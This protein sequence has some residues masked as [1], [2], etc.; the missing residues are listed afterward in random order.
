MDR[1]PLNHKL[2]KEACDKFIENADISVRN[3]CKIIIDNTMYVSYENFI[4]RIKIIIDEYIQLTEHIHFYNSYRPIFIY[5]SINKDNIDEYDILK[6]KSNYWIYKYVYKLLENIIKE[7]N[8]SSTSF[9]TKLIAIN[10]LSNTPELQQ[11]D[12]I[13]FVDDCIFSGGQ[14]NQTFLRFLNTIQ[15][16]TNPDIYN[17]YML[18]PYGSDNAINFIKRRYYNNPTLSQVVKKRRIE[19]LNKPIFPNQME[20]ITSIRSVLNI[21]Q[22]ELL[23]SFYN[24]QLFSIDTYLIYFDH[25]LADKESVPTIFYLGVVPNNYNKDL[26]KDLNS[27]KLKEVSKDLQLIPIINNCENYLQDLDIMEPKCPFTPYKKD[28]Y[29]NIRQLKKYRNSI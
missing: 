3:I 29:Y 17:Y 18:I 23:E 14:F 10:N 15:R 7:Y 28:F 19:H 26:I 24:T 6:F 8:T 11:N 21:N 16:D 22:C 25:K 1:I 5:N 4:R 27:S 20:K 2:N 9:K 13:L 12:F